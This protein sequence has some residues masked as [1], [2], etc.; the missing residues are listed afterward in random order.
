MPELGERQTGRFVFDVAADRWEWDDDVFAIHGYAPGEVEPTTDLFLK[1]KHEHD[2]E[3]VEQTF[4]DAVA[5]GEPFNVYYRIRA[6][7]S[8]RRVV[9]VGEGVR[10]ETGEVTH[11]AGYYLDLTPEFSAESAAAADAAVAASAAARDTIEQAKGV[12][13]LGYGLD[14]DAAFA[15]LR[16]W[17]RNRNVKV[18]DIAERLLA[19]ARE[20]HVSHPGLRRLLDTLIDDLTAERRGTSQWRT[21]D[22]PTTPE[23]TK[24]DADGGVSR[25]Q[26]TG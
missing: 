2:R 22:R 7:G 26:P 5:T 23:P 3:R 6:R 4:R 9:V 24:A 19:V 21:A 13:M 12:L 1:H 10:A 18:R 20:G 25:P 8:E 17:S 14:A 16:W 11:L 15:M